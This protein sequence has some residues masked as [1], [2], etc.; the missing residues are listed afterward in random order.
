MSALLE[1]NA[2]YQAVTVMRIEWGQYYEEPLVEEH[3]V[4]GRATLIMLDKGGE[5]IGR[6]RW[7]NSKSQIEPLFKAAI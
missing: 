6:V 4:L 7:Y 3:K 2:A 5:E 1:E